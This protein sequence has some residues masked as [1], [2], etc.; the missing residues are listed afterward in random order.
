MPLSLDGTGSII[1]I[2]TVSV[3]DDLTHVGDVNTKISF[4]ANDTISFET[5]G[6]EKV[7]ITSNG[8][9]VIGHTAS[10]AID[11]GHEFRFQ[12]SGTNFPTSGISQ[13][14]F[15]NASSGASL[16]L[17]HSRNDTQGS[18]TALQSNDEYGKIRFYGSDGTDFDG[19]GAAIVAKVDG[20]V[21][22]NSTP[23]RLEFHTTASGSNN[24]TEKLRIASTGNVS[25]GTQNVTEGKLQVNGDITAKLQHGS[26]DMY[27]MLAGRK[28]DGTSAMGGYAIRYGSGY[29][30]PWIV[31]YNAGSSYDNQITFGSMTT[32][33]RSLATGVQKRM[34]IDM[35]SGFVGIGT[36]DPQD[37]LHIESADPAIRLSDSANG[38]YAF[39]DGNSGNLVL[40]SDKGASGGSSTVK[41]A[42][43]NNVKVTVDSSGDLEIHDGDLKVASGHGIDFSA[44]ANGTGTNHNEL[45]DDYEEGDW[46]PKVSA[47]GANWNTTARYTKVGRIVTI[48]ADI[49]NTSGGGTTEIHNLPFAV[50]SKYGTWH[51]GYAAVN[52]TTTSGNTSYTGGL[53]HFTGNGFLRARASGGTGNI[54]MGNNHR[55]IFTATY[56]TAQ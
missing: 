40:H 8:Q 43:D 25:I 31:G 49:T 30:T 51:V 34:V 12:V 24:A 33:D 45:L 11:I 26:S 1:G 36:A 39:I 38:Q 27:G 54:T 50:D 19:Y 42:V 7:R 46:Q 35:A 48:Q 13:Q 21:G 4:P 28:F 44:T 29:E 15:Q 56:F 41:F 3:S 47:G 32:S 17:A 23:G 37:E 20:A 53:V 22:V 14:R 2:S 6:S 10:H 52:G 18:H 5:S 16:A 9:L 55:T